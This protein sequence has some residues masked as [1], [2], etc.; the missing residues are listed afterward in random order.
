METS[1]DEKISVSHLNIRPSIS[2]LMIQLVFLD[3]L[4]V[5]VL[6]ISYLLLVNFSAGVDIILKSVFSLVVLLA[7]FAVLVITT[8][9]SVLQWVNDYYELSPQYLVHKKGVIFRKIERFSMDHIRYCSVN[10]GLFGKLLNFG[11][12]TFLDQRRIKYLDLYLIHNPTKYLEVFEK[13]N[14]EID[15]M[16]EVMREKIIEESEITPKTPETLNK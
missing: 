14:P 9:Y 6:L 5:S 4:A 10:Q 15:E 7:V 1:G 13:I 2:I 16:E 8:I 11:T 12:I 3:V